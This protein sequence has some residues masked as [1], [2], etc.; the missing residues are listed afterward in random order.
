MT[1][2]QEI[3]TDPSYMAQI[4]AFT[5]PHI[6]NVGTNVEDLEQMSGASETAAAARSSARSRPIQANWRA[7]SDFD[8][9]MKRRGMVG[10]AG[11]DT[12]ALTRKIR[13]TGM[14]H[15]VIAHAPTASSTSTPW[16]PRPRPGPAWKAWTWPRTPRPPRPSPGTRAC[17]RGRKATPSWTSPSTR[18]WSSTTASS[19][20]SCGPWPMSAPAPRWCRP[21][22]RP[23]TSWPAIPT[24]C[25]CPTARATRPRPASMRCPRSR[26][27]SPAASRCSAS[28]WATRCWPS[29]WAPRP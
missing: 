17:G 5:F 18:S 4:V 29:R 24:A 6:G 9:W 2:Y 20:T 23:R 27:W 19:A 1:G 28:A 22:P 21:T 10:L 12:R 26:S 25:C 16:S 13:E 3:L 11:V 14:P 15:G 7:N 8:G